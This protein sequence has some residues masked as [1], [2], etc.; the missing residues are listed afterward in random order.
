MKKEHT[1]YH[2]IPDTDTMEQGI[3]ESLSTHNNKEY[4][5]VIINAYVDMDGNIMCKEYLH[6]EYPMVELFE[7]PQ[8]AYNNHL[9]TM[10][11]NVKNICKK[12][13]TLIDLIHFPL[14]NDMSKEENKMAYAIRIKEICGIDI[15]KIKNQ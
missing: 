6:K 3:I 10:Q 5:H 2:Y 12:I 14:I 1:I 11:Q 9:V 4:V 7:S 13:E 8:E 15:N